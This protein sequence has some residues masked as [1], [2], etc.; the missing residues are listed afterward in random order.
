MFCLE[1]KTTD[2]VVFLVLALTSSVTFPTVAVAQ[3]TADQIS[4]S[5]R[6]TIADLTARVAD[7]E[8]VVARLRAVQDEPWLTTRRADEIRGLVQDVLADAD[9]RS[10]LLQNG[11]TAG[12][13]RGFYLGSA[14]GNFLLKVNGRL[15]ARFV[16]NTQDN[17]ADDDERW[18]FENRRT[19]LLFNGHV[20]DP[21]LHYMI[22]TAMSR[23]GGEVRVLN[24]FITK[25]LGDSWKL[26][27]G[28]FKPPFMREE[29]MSSTR[30]LT[31]ERSL[32]NEE[33]NQARSQGVELAYNG[34]LLNAAVMI[35]EGFRRANT[36]ALAEDTEFAVTARAEALTADHVSRTTRLQA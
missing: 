11:M 14:D 17:S 6:K 22:Q 26:R 35:N 8:G 34:D 19:Q 36:P 1:V 27:V 4:D 23:V 10:S 30:Q 9:T 32:V 28:Q 13:N 12:W 20:I 21:S 33:F 25:D 24:A 16:Y 5:A 29:L 3:D 31:V 7:L 18:G 15:Q 2:R